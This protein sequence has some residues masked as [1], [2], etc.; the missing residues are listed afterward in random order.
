[1]IIITRVYSLNAEL[2][3]DCVRFALTVSLIVYNI[4]HMCEVGKERF[5]F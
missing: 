3:Q 4:L 2:G 5:I 1:M